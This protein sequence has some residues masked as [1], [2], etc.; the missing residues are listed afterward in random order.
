MRLTADRKSFEEKEFSGLAIAETLVSMALALG[1][2]IYANTLFYLAVAVT[3]APFLLLR[4]QQSAALGLRW[5]KRAEERLRPRGDKSGFFLDTFFFWILLIVAL[6]I[7]IVVALRFL[8]PGLKALP[9]NWYRVVFC[10][11][12]N[13][14]PEVIPGYGSALPSPPDRGTGPESISDALVLGAIFGGIVAVSVSVMVFF[15]FSVLNLLGVI[16]IFVGG[17]GLMMCA[18]AIFLFLSGLLYRFSLKATSIV[19]LPLLYV[20]KDATRKD[21]HIT[22]ELKI[23]RGSAQWKLIRLFSWAVIALVS[24]KILV[25]PSVVEW[26]NTKPWAAILNVYV[27]PGTV[28]A[29]HLAALINAA[30]ALFTYYMYFDKAPIY[31]QRRAW[32]P[33]VVERNLRIV[34]VIRAFISMYT[35]TVGVYL[36]ILAART[37]PLPSFSWRIWPL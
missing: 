18:G 6:A 31:I 17:S 25:L 34:R 10:L 14:L 35:I 9:G 19:W 36:T 5:F 21:L 33:E 32:R 26:W 24:A 4:S 15:D 1:L 27:M 30:L 28:H 23:I 2:A 13:V 22:D 37:M 3:L 8:V 12:S 20:V 11:D 29:W 16:G 7:R